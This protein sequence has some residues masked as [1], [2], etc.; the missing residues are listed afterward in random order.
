[1]KIN[2]YYCPRCD[3]NTCGEVVDGVQQCTLCRSILTEPRKNRGAV[4]GWGH[5]PEQPQKSDNNGAFEEFC[6]PDG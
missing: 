4:R 1:M 6:S 3:F 5:I 2:A